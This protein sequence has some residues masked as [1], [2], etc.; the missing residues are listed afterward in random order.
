MILLEITAWYAHV[1]TRDEW[2]RKGHSLPSLTPQ[3]SAQSVCLA[4]LKPFSLKDALT[5]IFDP[6][7]AF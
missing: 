4:P 6:D 2:Q 3:G 7:T 1:A 5:F